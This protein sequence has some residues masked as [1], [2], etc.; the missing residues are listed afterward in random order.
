VNEEET[1]AT[2]V[3]YYQTVAFMSRPWHQCSWH[4]ACLVEILVLN[5]GEQILTG[6]QGD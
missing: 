1:A 4:L 6:Q 2:L 5:R 3:L